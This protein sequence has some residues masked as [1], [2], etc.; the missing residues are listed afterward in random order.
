MLR[1]VTP[2]RAGPRPRNRW[3]PASY[4]AIVKLFP[5]VMWQTS[6]GFRQAQSP[7]SGLNHRSPV[8]E[9]VETRLAEQCPAEGIEPY[10]TDIQRPCVEILQVEARPGL[11]IG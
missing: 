10:G 2:P 11:Q 6:R 1:N 7:G 5:R 8:V 3:N 9:P 4:Q